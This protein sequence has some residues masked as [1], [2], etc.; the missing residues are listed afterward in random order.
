M[1]F[2]RLNNHR[3][4]KSF[5]ICLIPYRSAN[6]VLFTLKRK[7]LAGAERYLNGMRKKTLLHLVKGSTESNI[8]YLAHAWH[9]GPFT[10]KKS[11]ITLTLGGLIASSSRA[12]IYKFR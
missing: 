4:K 12:P 2:L 3:T 1:I 10:T 5:N 8:F 6:L 9:G 7:N 11:F